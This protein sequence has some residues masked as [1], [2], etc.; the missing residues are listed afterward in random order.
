[1]A[2]IVD[3]GAARIDACRPSA[4]RGEEL[5]PGWCGVCAVCA[6]RLSC[7][8]R[9]GWLGNRAACPNSSVKVIVLR[10]W[11]RPVILFGLRLVSYILQFTLA[12]LRIWHN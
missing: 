11:G 7:F 8:A 5:G 1:M 4:A 6:V 9:L 2:A 10:R 3:G 12:N